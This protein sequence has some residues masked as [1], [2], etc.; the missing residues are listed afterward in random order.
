MN[1]SFDR[2]DGRRQGQFNPQFTSQGYGQEDESFDYTPAMDDGSDTYEYTAPDYAPSKRGLFSSASMMPIVIVLGL[3]ALGAGMGALL[4]TLS[5]SGDTTENLPVIQ[6]QSTPFRQGPPAAENTASEPTKPADASDLFTELESADQNGK[7]TQ[8]IAL[9]GPPPAADLAKPQTSASDSQ[10]VDPEAQ[11][12]QSNSPSD[13]PAP[14]ILDSSVTAQT[15]AAPE[16]LTPQTGNTGTEIPA[17]LASAAQAQAGAKADIRHAPATA[18]ETLEFVK[19]VLDEKKSG[20]QESPQTATASKPQPELSA[21]E[22]ATGAAKPAG[23]SIT[24]GDYFVQLASVP[25]QDAAQR[26]WMKMLK[27][28]GSILGEA[29]YRVHEANLGER[30]TFYRVQ[31]GPMSKQSAT[32]VCNAIKAQKPGGCLIVK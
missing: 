11:A 20:P 7:E 28:Y 19:S 18:P 12:D 26:E 13:S 14:S 24:A 10:T 27:S 15:A 25:N 32:S 3:V 30:G 9:G 1:T 5:S 21:I 22:P 2:N 17:E 16:L 6:A 8:N 31:A 4:G 29:P 23:I